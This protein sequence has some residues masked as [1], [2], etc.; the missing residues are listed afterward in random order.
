ME[1]NTGDLSCKHSNVWVNL[2][3]ISC[4]AKISKA[5]N[6]IRNTKLAYGCKKDGTNEEKVRGG[7]FV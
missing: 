3:V 6:N 4:K 5:A 7:L 1:G 2:S